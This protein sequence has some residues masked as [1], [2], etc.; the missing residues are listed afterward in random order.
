MVNVKKHKELSAKRDLEGRP[1]KNPESYFTKEAG[2]RTG[3]GFRMPFQKEKKRMERYGVAKDEIHS[4]SDLELSD[5][6]TQIKNALLQ[7]RTTEAVSGLANYAELKNTKKCLAR[8]ETEIN[9]RIINDTWM[10]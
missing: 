10:C 5:T 6:R 4:M 7:L 1:E 3:G 9:K 2:E 8:V